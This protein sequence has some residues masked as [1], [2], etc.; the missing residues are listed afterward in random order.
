MSISIFVCPTKYINEQ[1]SEHKM[2]STI[3]KEIFSKVTIYASALC[4]VRRL[5]LELTDEE[6]FGQMKTEK[7]KLRV[8][9]SQV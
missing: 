9:A 3:N 8:S 1:Y 6:S 5:N 7:L 4:A 2:F